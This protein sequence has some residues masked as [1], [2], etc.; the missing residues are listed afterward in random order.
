M[1]TNDKLNI[2][3]TGGIPGGMIKGNIGEL[4]EDEE[5]QIRINV[6]TANEKLKSV[7][8]EVMRDFARYLKSQGRD[9]ELYCGLFGVISKVRD[10]ETSEIWLRSS[11]IEKYG[12]LKG[13]KNEN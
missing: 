12:K 1:K 4:T 13:A 2:L 3:V 8:N 5:K 11:V 9:I 10:T 6:M 7:N